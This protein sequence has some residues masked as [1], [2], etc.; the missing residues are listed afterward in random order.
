MKEKGTALITTLVLS[1]IC[2]ALIGG[3]I[4]LMTTGIRILGIKARYTSALEAAKGG[5]EDFIQSIPFNHKGTAA[6][7]DYRCK[8]QQ[9]TSNWSV[10]CINYCRDECTSHSNPQD[11]IN[12]YDWT[13]T[14]GNYTVYCKI[15][16]AK[17][18]SDGSWF[19]TIE[20]VAKNEKTSEIAWFTILYRRSY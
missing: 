19:Y 20:V 2:L 4:S 11:I 13:Q 15:I 9:D 5:L 14:Y 7:T 8:I 6:D 1:V 17:G 16:D 3:V 10:T 12:S 18:V